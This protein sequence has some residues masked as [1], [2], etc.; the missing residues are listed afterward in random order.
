[1][2]TLA[3]ALGVALQ[4]KG[5]AYHA[6]PM[7]VAAVWLGVLV[8]AGWVGR[9]AAPSWPMRARLRFLAGVGVVGLCVIHAAMS[10]HLVRDPL[11]L[12]AFAPYIER[13]TLPDERV[14]ILN[15]APNPAHPLL[16]ALQRR[17][18]SRYA[19]AHPFPIA[20]VGYDGLPAAHPQHVAPPYLQ[21]YLDALEADLT[22]HQPPLVFIHAERCPACPQGFGNLHDYLSVRGHLAAWLTPSYALLTQDRGYHIYVRRD[23]ATR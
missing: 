3:S 14:L 18:A 23:L 22:L 13:Y 17:S 15:T 11:G 9:Q 4:G 20:Y 10:V 6:I 7:L 12:F 16:N 8:L 21:D 19:M 2:M 5:W 1:M